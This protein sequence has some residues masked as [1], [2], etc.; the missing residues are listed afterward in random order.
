VAAADATGC[1]RVGI[2]GFCMGGMVTYK[3]SATGRF[4]RAVAFYGMVRLPAAWRSPTMVDP[5]E[6]L[7]SAQRCPV[8]AIIGTNDEF[9]PPADIAEAEALGV[10][11]VRYEG[12]NHGFVHDPARPTHRADDAADAWRRVLAF[13][14]G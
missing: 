10:D 14:A 13:L 11:V 1:A 2:L 5:V 3:A 9:L 4:D 8:L 7:A 6:A 12:A